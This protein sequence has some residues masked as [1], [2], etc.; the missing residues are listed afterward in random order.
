MLT[1]RKLV[2]PEKAYEGSVRML[3]A[4]GFVCIVDESDYEYLRQ[5]R[6]FPKKSGSCF[7][8]VRKIRRGGKE[9]LIRMH[10]QLCPARPDEDVHHKNHRSMDNRRINLEPLTREA[11][12]AKHNR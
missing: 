9:H 8:A 2:L 1:K 7:Y 6:W 10:R 4:D 3:I 5:F 12:N 11:H